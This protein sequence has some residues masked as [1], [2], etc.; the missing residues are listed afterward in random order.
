MPS[1]AIDISKPHKATNRD[2][3]L[4]VRSAFD[5]AHYDDE[6]IDEYWID[7]DEAESGLK[8]DIKTYSDEMDKLLMDETKIYSII[9]SRHSVDSITAINNHA[10][11]MKFA[12]K[13]YG[14]AE[15]FITT[16]RIY[17]SLGNAATKVKRVVSLFK[18][19]SISIS[20]FATHIAEFE[21]L[22][23]QL[24]TD[25]GKV[26][27]GETVI[28]LDCLLSIAFVNALPQE[29]FKIQL[30]DLWKKFPDGKIDNFKQLTQEFEAAAAHL[31][32]DESTSVGAAFAAFVC[33]YCQSINRHGTGH[34]HEYC[35]IN[36]A[37]S[38]KPFF[39]KDRHERAIAYF[40]NGAKSINNENKPPIVNGATTKV[41]KPV[42]SVKAFAAMTESSDT[43]ADSGSGC[44]SLLMQAVQQAPV[45]S[46]QRNELAATLANFLA[47][48]P[49]AAAAS[50]DA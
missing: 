15:N 28:P 23:K 8:F 35:H 44:I 19:T 9:L 6:D 31:P 10:K 30:H 39:R 2:G 45:G 5:P 3:R 11:R 16:S 27:D 33:T 42:K 4:E 17:H 40:K 36:P 14:N 47:Q 41:K 7:D 29:L 13:C 32:I 48:G 46:N 50:D 43:A 49:E 38:D 34:K 37:N 20:S 21:N 25:L 12:S 18:D 26:V 1:F 24:G 22:G